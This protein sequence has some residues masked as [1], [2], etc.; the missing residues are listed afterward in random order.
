MP[1]LHHHT[2]AI[3]PKPAHRLHRLK[4]FHR[5]H[6]FNL[7]AKG[8]DMRRIQH[9][10]PRQPAGVTTAFELRGCVAISITVGVAMVEVDDLT[11]VH[12]LG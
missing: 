11:D 6:G 8:V 10:I 12:V 1:V 9:M 7:R 4:E 5:S 2:H 3:V